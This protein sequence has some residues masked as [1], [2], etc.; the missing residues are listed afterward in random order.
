M[1]NNFPEFRVNK[2][3]F[4]RK[5]EEKIEKFS[6]QNEN[7]MIN[8]DDIMKEVEL[9]IESRDHPK[10]KTSL[11]EPGKE[12]S[13][14]LCEVHKFQSMDMKLDSKIGES[15]KFESIAGKLIRIFELGQK[16]K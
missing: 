2:I 5:T 13:R 1:E 8:D 4:F 7:L 9:K 16:K 12:E 11:V 14:N 10:T 6:E 3:C 15:E